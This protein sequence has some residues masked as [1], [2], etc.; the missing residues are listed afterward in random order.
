MHAT[1]TLYL[2]QYCIAVTANPTRPLPT[3]FLRHHELDLMWL[4]AQ[5]LLGKH[6]TCATVDH[7]Y[8]GS[9]FTLILPTTV[10]QYQYMPASG[11][12]SCLHVSKPSLFRHKA[13][14]ACGFSHVTRRRLPMLGSLRACYCTAVHQGLPPIPHHLIESE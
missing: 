9:S 12:I 4:S 3:L 10:P 11:L 13:L 6:R 14:S 2:P 1:S 7:S 8:S 5:P